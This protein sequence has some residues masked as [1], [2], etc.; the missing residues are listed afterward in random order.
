MNPA[1]NGILTFLPIVLMS[2]V[3]VGPVF[4]QV[5]VKYTPSGSAIPNPERGF[6]TELTSQAE[7]G[8]LTAREVAQCKAKGQSLIMRMYYL[9][10][11]R[12]LPL[13]DVELNIVR[14]DFK[15]IRAAGMKCIPRFAYSHNIGQQDAP[16]NIV[17]GHIAQ[18]KPI[19]RANEDVIAAMQ[20]GFIGAWGEMHS[21]T[22]GLDSVTN[23]RKILF[24]LLRMLPP[25]RMIQ[26]RTPNY[27]R[28]IFNRQA[29]IARS[30]AFNES[31]YSRVGHHNDCFL[32]N[33][34]DYGTYSDTSEETQFLS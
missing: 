10:S 18:L 33:W 23:M 11:F 30:E 12:S 20:A 8:Q 17:M 34:N 13:S 16:L 22:N 29:P 6:Y 26:V 9:S 28:E 15:V 27:K 19:I 14:N 5:D 31:M 2:L 4:A 7:K 21:S 1:R 24:E 25:E 32:A 3:L